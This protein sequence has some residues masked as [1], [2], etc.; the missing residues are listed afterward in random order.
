MHP[1][2]HLPLGMTF[3]TFTAAVVVALTFAVSYIYEGTLAR[4]VT[5]RALIGLL[6]VTLLAGFLGARG[7]YFV[8]YG[9]DELLADPWVLLDGQGGLCFF[10]GMLAF[11]ATA[12]PVCAATGVPG[13]FFLAICAP[14]L[15]VGQAIGR[16]GCL[17]AGCCYGQ[18][19]ALPWCFAQPEIAGD[20]VPRHPVQLYEMVLL[21][22]LGAVLH[23]LRVRGAAPRAVFGGYLTALSVERALLECL[24]GDTVGES[25]LFG[26]T[27]AQTICAA[28]FV[29]GIVK[30]AR[31]R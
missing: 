13:E 9:P 7:S 21:L 4:G 22:A 11:V 15:A 1:T 24:R 17:A 10:G 14:A 23:R 31:S 30:L 20:A 5:R 29:A 3:P 6:A 16:V 2:L 12:V 19:G 26:M 27:L 8:F 18:P 28:L 25:Y